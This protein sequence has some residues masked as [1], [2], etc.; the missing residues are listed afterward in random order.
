MRTI[1]RHAA[2]VQG[3]DRGDVAVY[4]EAAGS[5]QRALAGWPHSTASA[6]STGVPSHRI[7]K[8]PSSLAWH[9]S[10][11]FDSPVAQRG[12]RLVCVGRLDCEAHRVLG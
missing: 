12:Q 7:C 4:I 9:Y 11:A 3:L 1:E 10:T 2:V 8:L 5:S 6:L